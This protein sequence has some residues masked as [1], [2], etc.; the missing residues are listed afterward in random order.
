MK[1]KYIEVVSKLM[2]INT[3][4][5]LI[6]TYK[7]HNRRFMFNCRNGVLILGDECYG[8]NIRSSHS[9]EF[10]LSKVKG[11]F[12]DYLRGWIGRGYN[13]PN[14]I[15]HFAPSISKSQF[16]EGYD[17]LQ[18]LSCQTGITNETIIRGFY[19]YYEIRLG[20]LVYHISN[21]SED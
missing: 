7:I 10:Y 18:M 20:E 9:E 3:K 21:S 16:D 13:Y 1:K 15:I 11:A 2:V 19:N 5:H 12:D 8:K 4:L 17:L 6:D 14:G